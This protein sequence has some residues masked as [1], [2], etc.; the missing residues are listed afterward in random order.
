[1]TTKERLHE[2]V[3]EL[4]ELEADDA[5]RMIEARRAG[6]W[7]AQTPQRIELNDEEAER[8][9]DALDHPERFEAGVERLKAS[10]AKHR[11]E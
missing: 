4:S 5:L 9:L 7:L 8:F 11:G 3:D 1:M 2:I 10:A 6:E